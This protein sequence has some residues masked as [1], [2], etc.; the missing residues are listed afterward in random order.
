MLC[1]RQM[2]QGDASP[3]SVAYY[4]FFFEIAPKWTKRGARPCTNDAKYDPCLSYSLTAFSWV[5]VIPSEFRLHAG[6]AKMKR[7]I[8]CVPYKN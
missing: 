2:L 6:P 3:A 4:R 1:D 5:P 7:I 8:R